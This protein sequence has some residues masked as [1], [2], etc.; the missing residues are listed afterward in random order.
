MKHTATQHRDIPIVNC[1]ILENAYI[2][3]QTAQT[4][5]IT[6]NHTNINK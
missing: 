5:R 3:T 1:T 2:S 4:V 6:T